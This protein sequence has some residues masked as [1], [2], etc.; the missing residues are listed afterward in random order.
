[1]AKGQKS[2]E[3]KAQALG[4][5]QIEYVPVTSIKPNSYNPNRQSDH[6][7]ELLCHSILEDGFTQPIVCQRSSREFVDGEH[8]WTGFIVTEYM[9][10]N[11]MIGENYTFDRTAVPSLRARRLEIAAPD[12][13][14]PVVFV[15]MTVEQMRIATLRHNKARGSHDIELETQVLRDLQELGALE[16][17][18]DSLMMSDE[19]INRLLEDIPAPE[20]LAGEEYEQAWEPSDTDDRDQE[21]VSAGSTEAREISST[22]HNGK[23]ITAMTA[24]AIEDL[25]RKEQAIAQAK[26]EEEREMAKQQTKLYRVSLIFSNAEAETVET[27]LGKEPAVKLLELCQRELS[28]STP[29]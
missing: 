10:R 5:L 6:E 29:A 27:V 15:D 3:K 9:K 2:I 1:M 20:A 4:V 26:T 24:N 17:A 23:H 7:F 18:Q 25:R 19:E 28:T 11:G 21:A 16:W 13:M 22:T 12:M 8:R 14:I